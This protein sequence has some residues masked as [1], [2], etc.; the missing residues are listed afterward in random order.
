MDEIAGRFGLRPARSRAAKGE[1]GAVAARL[2]GAAGAVVVFVLAA[3]LFLGNVLADAG[4]EPVPVQEVREG[5]LSA[6]AYADVEL[7][8]TK[9]DVLTALR[10]VLPV[11]TRVVE[12]YELRDPETVAAECLFF[13]REDGRA[14]QQ[15]R[16][17][18]HE[19]LLV[20]KTV[21]LAGDP[22][23]GSAV[24]EDEGVG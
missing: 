13:D 20:D 8:A 11:D 4:D 16:F 19:D 3:F 18:F 10:P 1:A 12:R 2:L 21:I 24:V 15:F 23:E 7:G 17:C 9:E 22:G 5:R 14:G 6:A